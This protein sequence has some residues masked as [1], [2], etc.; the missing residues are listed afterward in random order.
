MFGPM[1]SSTCVAHAISSLLILYSKTFHILLFLSLLTH[2]LVGTEAQCR[3]KSEGHALFVEIMSD[4]C[5]TGAE[6][7]AMAMVGDAIWK[8]IARVKW[9]EEY[10]G[11]HGNPTC[12]IHH[13]ELLYIPIFHTVVSISLATHCIHQTRI[14]IN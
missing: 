3:E 6:G 4:V 10:L 2:S 8:I 12:H 14:L 5:R 11:Q 1:R 7:K 13:N 9:I